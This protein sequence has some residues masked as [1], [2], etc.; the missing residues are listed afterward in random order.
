MLLVL[1]W[2]VLGLLLEE[3]EAC[4]EPWSQP[5]ASGVESRFQPASLCFPEQEGCRPMALSQPLVGHPGLG[6]GVGGAGLHLHLWLGEFSP[7]SIRDYFVSS[8]V[9]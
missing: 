2:N 9:L 5:F 6:A 3:Q 1:V 4:V 7:W 8:D